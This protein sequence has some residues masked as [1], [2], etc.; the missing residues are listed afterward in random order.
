M[1][2][3]ISMTQIPPSGTIKF[4]SGI[5]IRPGRQRIFKTKAERKAYFDAHLVK[6]FNDM[7]YIRLGRGIQIES[8]TLSINQCNYISYKNKAVGGYEDEIFARIDPNWEYVNPSTVRINFSVDSWTTYMFDIEMK[9]G[10]VQREHMSETDWTAAVANPYAD[11]FQLQTSEELPMDQSMERIADANTGDVSIFPS[12][13]QH[14]TGNVVTADDMRL[15]LMLGQQDLDNLNPVDNIDMANI[16][17]RIT[18]LGGTIRKDTL[19][20]NIPNPCTLFIMKYT[21]D[22]VGPLPPSQAPPTIQVVKDLLKLLEYNNIIG[23]IVGLYWIPHEYVDNLNEYYKRTQISAVPYQYSPRNPKLYRSP[24]CYLRVSDETGQFKHY[25]WENF[26]NLILNGAISNYVKFDVFFSQVGMP[27][28]FAAPRQYKT[29]LASD[30]YDDDEMLF[31]N[32]DEAVI[33]EDIPYLPYTTDGYVS[34][35]GTQMRNVYRGTNIIK[36]KLAD[37]NQDAQARSNVRSPRYLS[38][39]ATDKQIMRQAGAAVA[40]GRMTTAQAL[41]Q[42]RQNLRNNLNEINGDAQ[43]FGDKATKWLLGISPYL[44]K[45]VVADNYHEGSKGWA[46]YMRA[47]LRFIFQKVCPR[48]DIVEQYDKYF[49][50]FGYNSGRIGL[51][52]VYN[53]I[54]HTGDQPH[55]ATIDGEQV[56][57]C[58]AN[59]SVVLNGKMPAVAANEIE[60]MFAQGTLFTK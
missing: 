9:E 19:I 49:D 45:A 18:T 3:N 8:D 2:Q 14:E 37:A 20:Q 30:V 5:D 21:E 1:A 17:T 35:L 12:L 29:I 33:H 53:Y 55:F 15:V 41:S 36:Y 13:P 23:N 24:Y 52:Y 6:S 7:S 54:K 31:T 42:N 4:Y 16:E 26:A 34:E 46:G 25:E 39:D 56:T 28:L 10:V 50:Y 60:A 22:Y 11:I 43:T 32:V 27:V 47:P 38:S 40:E 44:Q 48:A 58:Q 51:P 59:I 57:Y